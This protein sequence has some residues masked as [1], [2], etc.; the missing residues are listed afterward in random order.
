M[1]DLPKDLKKRLKKAIAHFWTARGSQ[2]E[3]QGGENEDKDRGN[4]GSVTG[5]KHLDGFLELIAALLEEAGLQR[6]HIFWQQK[7]E[8]P[9][10]FRA[11]KNW[12]L[13]VVADGKLIAIAEF[14][15]Q[16]GSFGNNF[17]NRTEE[18]LGNATDLWEAFEKGAFKLSERPWLGYLM[19]LEDSPKVLTPVK[20]QEPHFKVFEEFKGASYQ[21]RYEQLMTRLVRK[22][23]YDACCLL[24]S[25]QAGG[26]SGKYRE[27]N[28][29]LGFTPFVTSLF[30][31]ASA[32]ARMQPR[33]PTAPPTIENG[34]AAS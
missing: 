21:Q 33:G 4:R 12:D 14:K 28:P 8:L 19:L 3:K 11:E 22:R 17:N 20:V 23:L 34:P 18:A 27:P 15:S 32:A 29:E 16:V 10:W 25:S 31:K 5:G 9:G 30:A 26:V 6:S 2:A 13:L 24:M 1:Q 7:T